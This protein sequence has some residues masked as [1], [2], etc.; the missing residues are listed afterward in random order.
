MLKFI[1][2]YYKA[3]KM[4]KNTVKKLPSIKL[5]IPD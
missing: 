5:Y 4:C 1:P 2:D 3:K